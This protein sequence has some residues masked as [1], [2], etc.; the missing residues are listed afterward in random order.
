M[1]GFDIVG[2]ISGGWL[3]VDQRARSGMEWVMEEGHSTADKVLVDHTRKALKRAQIIF[4][5]SNS[6]PRK[7][8]RQACR[9]IPCTTSEIWQAV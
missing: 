3:E 8:P 1:F 5:P 4:G 9:D 7:R 2:V 6:K